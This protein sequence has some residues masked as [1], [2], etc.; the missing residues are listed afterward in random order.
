MEYFVI[1][2]SAAWPSFFKEAKNLGPQNFLF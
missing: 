1:G 2:S